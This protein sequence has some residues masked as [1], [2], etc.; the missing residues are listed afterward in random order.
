MPD[1][2]LDRYAAFAFDLDGV[3]WR[4]GTIFPEAPPAIRAIQDAGK[5]LLFLTN[6]ASYLPSW[7][8]EHLGGA[9]IAVGVESIMTSAIAAR[10][11]VEKHGLVGKRAFVMGTA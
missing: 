2:V 1:S 4:A 8:V 3:I 6:N 9:G 10:T 11:Y 7:I 5:R